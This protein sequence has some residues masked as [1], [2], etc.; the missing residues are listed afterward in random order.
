MLF[1]LVIENETTDDMFYRL[2][3]LQDIEDLFFEQHNGV[4]I[5]FISRVY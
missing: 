4:R 1:Y 2:A 5:R 3:N